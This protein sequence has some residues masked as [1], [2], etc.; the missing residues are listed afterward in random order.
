MKAAIWLLPAL[1]TLT[2]SCASLHSVPSE[3]GR[4][5]DRAYCRADPKD[6][7]LTPAVR[8]SIILCGSR[9]PRRVPGWALFP[10]MD[11]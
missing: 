3:A 4:H 8:H 2:T 1:V 11:T 6:A 9:D 10:T 5:A 7:G